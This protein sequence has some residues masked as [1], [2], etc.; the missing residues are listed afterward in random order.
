VWESYNSW[1]LDVMLKKKGADAPT[2]GS[3]TFEFFANKNQDSGDSDNYQMRC[4]PVFI[5]SETFKRQ[6]QLPKQKNGSNL[7]PTLSSSETINFHKLALRYSKELTKDM[8]FT[9]FRDI[10]RKIGEL[11]GSGKQVK[12]AFGVGVLTSKDRVADFLFNADKLKIDNEQ[13]NPV[14]V[15]RN[16]ANVEAAGVGESSIDIEENN[17][18]AVSEVPEISSSEAQF[19]DTMADS[20]P[21]DMDNYND[22]NIVDDDDDD[23]GEDSITDPAKYGAHEVQEEAFQRYGEPCDKRAKR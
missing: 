16:A 14:Y 10:V 8:I 19:M 6:Y 20:S 7:T 21:M 11:I 13:N 12:L 18:R 1:A 9:G 17:S 5:L 2:F 3:L 22:T 23:R 4:K 15:M